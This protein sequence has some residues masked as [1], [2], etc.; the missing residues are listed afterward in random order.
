MSDPRKLFL[1]DGLGAC[2]TVLLIAG[3]WIPFQ[4]LVGMPRFVLE[5][6]SLLGCVL[7][8]YSF[9]CFFFLKN[10][11][12]FFLKLIAAANALYVGLTIFFLIFYC[13]KLTVLGF[14]YFIIELIIIL[15][16]V[17]LEMKM[18]YKSSDK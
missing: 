4:N 16:L 17:F 14:T 13:E 8:L 7:A 2:L 15:G 18:A 11:R 6:F 1:V 5:I 10:N 12:R 3:I 9:S